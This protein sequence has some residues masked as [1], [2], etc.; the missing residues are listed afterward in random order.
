[1]DHPPVD[2]EEVHKPPVRKQW[3]SFTLEH[4]I[5][6]KNTSNPS[7]KETLQRNNSFACVY[8]SVYEPVTTE[9]PSS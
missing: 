9:I 5:T 6:E 7:E 8:F 3:P 2:G 1:M 4:S